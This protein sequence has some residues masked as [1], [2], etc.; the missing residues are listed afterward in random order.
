MMS[1][2]SGMLCLH[3]AGLLVAP[4]SEGWGVSRKRVRV[5][6]KVSRVAF[7]S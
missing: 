4:L 6:N 2:Y 5:K 7:K 1:K 3:S